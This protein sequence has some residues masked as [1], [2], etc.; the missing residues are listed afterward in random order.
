M[1]YNGAGLLSQAYDEL[2]RRTQNQYDSHGLTTATTEAAG[3]HQPSPRRPSRVAHPD[4]RRLPVRRRRPP[5]RP[6]HCTTTQYDAPPI[7]VG[8]ATTC[9]HDGET[10]RLL[11]VID[12]PAPPGDSPH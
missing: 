10:G 3:R 11:Q 12:P 6:R 8:A 2:G 9:V 5:T 7:P 4:R 1:V